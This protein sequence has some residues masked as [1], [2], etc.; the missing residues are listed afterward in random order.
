MQ[1]PIW[2]VLAI[3]GAAAV[4]AVIGGAASL[5]HRP[6]TLVSSLALG[7]AG[8]A[9]IATVAFEMVP[10]AMLMGQVPAVLAGFGLGFGGIWALELVL[11]RGK[12]AGSE[13][14]QRDQ[15]AQFHERV[16]PLGGPESVLGVGVLIET[17][18]EGLAIGIGG[19]VNLV[20]GLIIA[21]GVTLDNLT[22]GM[23]IGELARREARDGLRR[24][25]MTWAGAVA[26]TTVV[27]AV[28][29][30]LAV[31]HVPPLLLAG[32]FGA[33]AGI[34]LYLALAQLIPQAEAQQYQRSSTLAAGAA[35]S[36]VFVLSAT[37]GSLS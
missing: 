37:G 35:F 14:D 10:Q 22:E 8:G 20:A 26:V 3:S 17:A 19:G 25:V 7:T 5:W 27:T 16:Q 18:V 28:L 2:V 15:V 1:T 34:L 21:L 4:A 12:V 6:S 32:A 29:G 30:W 23:S 31:T 11:E 36:V 13:A 9:L 33:G 24:T